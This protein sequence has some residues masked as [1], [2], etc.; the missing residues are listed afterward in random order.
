MRVTVAFVISACL[1]LPGCF[2]TANEAL[3]P[4]RE[5]FDDNTFVNEDEHIKLTW[6]I[7]S[8]AT[9]RIALEK[10]EGPNVDLYTM[11]E[12]NYEKYK[13]CDSFVYLSDLS[14]PNTDASN[15][16]ANADAG[17]YVTVI[18]NTDCGEAQPPDQSG[19]LTSDENDRA[20]VDYRITAQ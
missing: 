13:D 18:D 11:T 9:I 12:V 6:T 14:D 15:L 4:E 17:T 19:L 1:L 20:R 5:L 10:Q 7:D 2:D 8:V 3:N 16:E